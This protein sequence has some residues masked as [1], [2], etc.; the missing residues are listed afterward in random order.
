MTP[1]EY[2]S[3]LDA[4][5]KSKPERTTGLDAVFAFEIAGARGGSWWIEARD[6]TGAVHDA[7]P[8]EPALTVRMSDETMLA[9]VS[10]ELDGTTAY[11]EEKM[12]VEGDQSQLAYLGQIFG[13]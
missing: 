3:S 2:M 10:G 8:A 12:T 13:E 5:L 1:K 7:E 9:M 6:G 11:F 4:E